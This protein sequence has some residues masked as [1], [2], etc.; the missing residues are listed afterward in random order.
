MSDGDWTW[1]FRPPAKRTY[2]DLETHG[3]ERI[4][5]KLDEIVNDQWRSPDDYLEP[6]TGVPTPSFESASS[7]SAQTAITRNRRWISTQSNAVVART[8]PATTSDSTPEWLVSW[9]AI[10]SKPR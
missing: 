8:N 2:D 1:Q 9:V 4:T 10:P 5:D 7:V 6:L 3:K